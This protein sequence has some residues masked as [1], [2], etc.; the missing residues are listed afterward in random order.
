MDSKLKN[1]YFFTVLHTY[2]WNKRLQAIQ[3]KRPFSSWDLSRSQAFWENYIRKSIE[4]KP[5]DFRGSGKFKS[6]YFEW[7]ISPRAT[8]M[9]LY[10]PVFRFQKLTSS[11]VLKLLLLLQNTLNPNSI[12][13]QKLRFHFPI[14]FSMNF[15]DSLESSRC[16]VH[17]HCF[18]FVCHCSSNHLWVLKK[19]P[20]PE[21]SFF[22]EKKI[23][24]FYSIPSC[25][26]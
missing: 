26:R 10:K 13:K 23:I 25:F 5:K 2:A 8:P 24:N 11:L 4:L 22:G 21:F 3:K 17:G 16:L 12:I 15:H 18:I 20:D 1:I 14:R 7:R 9:S 19:Y 6:G